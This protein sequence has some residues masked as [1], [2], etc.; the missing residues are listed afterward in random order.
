MQKP[1]RLRR[2]SIFVGEAARNTLVLKR[3]VTRR[4]TEDDFAHQPRFLTILKIKVPSQSSM[5]LK[6]RMETAKVQKPMAKCG[7]R[8]EQ[9]GQ[10]ATV[11]MLQTV[12]ESD[13]RCERA[14]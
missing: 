10:Q 11:A 8:I 1:G 9:P 7:D 6:P 2:K 12:T 13:L 4:D 14:A 5:A 3:P